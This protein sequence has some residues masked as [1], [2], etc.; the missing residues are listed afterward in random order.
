MSAVRS[1]WRA[2]A[3]WGVSDRLKVFLVAGS[4]MGLAAAQVLMRAP[5]KEGHDAF[6]S[7]KPLAV[8]G[9][10]VRSLETERAKMR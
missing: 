4:L 7:E 5:K 9:E 10:Q 2:F 6:S 8:R 3:A 1:A